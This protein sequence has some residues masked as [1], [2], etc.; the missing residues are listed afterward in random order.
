MDV[1]SSVIIEIAFSVCEEEDK[2]I[3]LALVLLSEHSSL[4]VLQMSELFEMDYP[5]VY[6]K[7]KTLKKELNTPEITWR[8]ARSIEKY[9]AAKSIILS[10][11][12]VKM[13]ENH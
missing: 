4:N 1:E 13:K 7:Y 12:L 5:T 2:D 11:M 6:Q 10:Y 9:R 3:S 8:N